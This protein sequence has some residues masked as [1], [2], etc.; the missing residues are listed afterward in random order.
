MLETESK[1]NI[2]IV[3]DNKSLQYTTDYSAGSLPI[4]GNASNT[5]NYLLT[6]LQL[7][8]EQCNIK[9]FWM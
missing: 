8:K 1:V 4:I 2:E 5:V 9:T 7:T 6:M 3:I